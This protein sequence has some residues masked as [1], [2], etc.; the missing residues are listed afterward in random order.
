MIVRLC[1]LCFFSLFFI[2]A[3]VM[4]AAGVD[5]IMQASSIWRMLLSLAVVIVIIPVA[6]FIIKK[7]QGVQKKLGKSPIKIVSAQS[8]GAK[9]KLIV[10]EVEQQRLLL[11]VTAHG[12]ALLKTLSDKD[13][14]FSSY[15][16]SSEVRKKS[17][18]EQSE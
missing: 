7:L 1:C 8:L 6:L 10:V 5:S 11:G 12:I 3:N 18:Q 14:E 16:N 15:I 17:P 9:E 13:V 4:S 2:S